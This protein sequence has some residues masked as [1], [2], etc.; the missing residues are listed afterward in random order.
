[1]RF[2]LRVLLLLLPVVS[3]PAQGP[4]GA[5][6]EYR[7][8]ERPFEDSAAVEAG[9]QVVTTPA[10][11]TGNR[12][13]PPRL[14]GW[15]IEAAAGA[16]PAPSRAL[17]VRTLGLCYFSGPGDAVVPLDQS[18]TYG[19]RRCRL[20]Q[21]RMPPGLAAYAYLAEVAPNLLA[22]AY[23]S[24]TPPGGDPRS[25]E[26][27]LTGLRLGA[28]AVP[29]EEGTALLKTLRHWADRPAAALDADPAALETEA[30]E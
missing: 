30:V 27:H 17:L 18:V 29:A 7:L 11:V 9:F 3:L 10:L 12:V 23:L 14:G 22:L 28:R 25:V 19:G 5:V 16:L 24:A 13:R 1:M 26:I 4:A 15:R 2:L 8:K 21:V 20:W 6:L